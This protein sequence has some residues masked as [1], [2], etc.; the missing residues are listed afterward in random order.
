M[1]LDALPQL[2]TARIGTT[3]RPGNGKFVHDGSTQLHLAVR[4]ADLTFRSGHAVNP[5]GKGHI[6]FQVDD[7]AEV[8]ARLAA[9]DVPFSDYGVWAIAGWYQIFFNDPAGNVVEC[10][11]TPYPSE[12]QRSR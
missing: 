10:F 4:D 11:E 7:I 8:K 1:G 5:L 6:A 9:H 12:R 2:E 3:V